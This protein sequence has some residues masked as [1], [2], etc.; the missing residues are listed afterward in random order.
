[1]VKKKLA[2]KKIIELNEECFTNDINKYNEI[3]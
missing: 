2:K 3:S 1:M